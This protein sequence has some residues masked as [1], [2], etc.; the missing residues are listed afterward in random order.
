MKFLIILMVIVAFASADTTGKEKSKYEVF[1]LKY[2]KFSLPPAKERDRMKTFLT[3]VKDVEKNN[4]DFLQ[5]KVTYVKAIN[6]FTDMT[7]KEFIATYCGVK[8]I[9][10][11][12]FPDTPVT[13]TGNPPPSLDL[14]IHPSYW[15][16]R[17]MMSFGSG[18]AASTVAAI[19]YGHW[20]KTGNITDLSEQQLIDCA[21]KGS[22]MPE[23]MNY[24]AES[25]GIALEYQYWYTGFSETCKAS[26]V[27]KTVSLVYGQ[28]YVHVASD[29][30]SI[31]NALTLGA[32]AVCVDPSG[33]SAYKTGIFTS[34]NYANP[35]CL[36]AVALVGY[37]TDETSEIPYWLVRNS[38][39]DSWWGEQGHMRL[40]ARRDP[41]T[42]KAFGGI[43]LENAFLPRIL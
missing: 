2:G 11:I 14:T 41:V 16:V 38:W 29:D 21:V 24:I 26:S 39:G 10:D 18:S 15:P 5:R 30:N 13:F 28:P 37:G 19:E 7:D 6:E 1:R 34:T 43:M 23:A 31:K 4:K 3:N 22:S 9:P 25:D 40:D 35:S 8:M 20:R 17:N 12:R 32:L 36:H 33:W 42:G 27:P